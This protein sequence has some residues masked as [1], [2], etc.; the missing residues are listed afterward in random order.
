MA[1]ISC[2]FKC[3]NRFVG[4][5]SV[6]DTYKQEKTAKEKRDAELRAIRNL[7]K[8]CYGIYTNRRAEIEK[9]NHRKT[10]SKRII[11]KQF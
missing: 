10:N 4:C 5:H 1:G 11:Y 9:K 3:P 6:C 2:C 7:D 8:A